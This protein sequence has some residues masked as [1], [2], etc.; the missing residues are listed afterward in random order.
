[1]TNPVCIRAG[2]LFSAALAA[3]C[4]CRTEPG[5]GSGPELRT[6]GAGSPLIRYHGRIDRRDPDA[7]AFDWPASGFTLR[8]TGTAVG[9]VIEDTGDNDFTVWIDGKKYPR[10]T[11]VKGE[12][13]VV[14]AGKLKPG[15]HQ[16]E[17]AKSTEAYQG[18][19]R[20][21]GILLSPDGELLPVPEKKLRI[22]VFGDSIS[23]GYGTAAPALDTG[24]HRAHADACLAWP[25]LV[26]RTLDAE[27]TVT[28]ASGKG[29]VRNW[30]EPG[31]RSAEN[32]PDTAW[33]VLY[34]DPEYLVD[35][36]EPAPDLII[37][38]LG[39]ND[40][41]PGY[42]L[43]E[44]EFGAA[45]LDFLA[46]VHTRWPGVPVLA[47]ALDWQPLPG[48]IDALVARQTAGGDTLLTGYSL[49]GPGTGEFGCDWHPN[50][51]GQKRLADSLLPE[52]KKLIDQDHTDSP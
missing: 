2:L 36:N 39:H 49:R 5:N 20:I 23:A 8:F 30:G 14:V 31:P 12:N 42:E 22:Q 21:R 33:R 35:P 7:P 17:F 45:W 40:T 43:S 37:I 11:A 25:Y 48:R 18:I 19:T 24:W 41:S 3:S 6:V 1:M 38:C 26:A 29:F 44:G 4:A 52:I 28:A 10:I 50:A 27:L 13:R 16:L 46:R 34:N 47:G 9:M 32:L 51:R 15:E